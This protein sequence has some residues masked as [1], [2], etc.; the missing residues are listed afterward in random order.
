MQP[1]GTQLKDHFQSELDALSQDAAVFAASYPGVADALRL[2][3]SGSSD[4]HVQMLL[5]TF[6]FLT[7]RVR[8][9]MQVAKAHIPNA[10]LQHL[11]PQLA[12][13]LP[14]MMVAQLE[15]K[16]DVPPQAVLA[17]GRQ[18]IGLA[19]DEHGQRHP[20]RLRTA[21]AVPLLP[22]QVAEVALLGPEDFDASEHDEAV[23]ALLRLRIRRLGVTPTAELKLSGLR[24]YI[25]TAH[26]HAHYL[27][28]QLCLSFHGVQ[29]RADDEQ[30]LITQ[31][32]CQPHW[33]GFAE[34]EAALPARANSH[35]GHRLI[36]EYFSFPEKFMFFE[37]GPLDFSAI[38]GDFELHIQLNAPIDGQRQLAN[39]VL[40][41]N[42][43]PLVNLFAQR[44]DP[45]PLSHRHY[46]YRLRADLQNHARCEI[47]SLEE[48]VAI[49]ADGSLR[50]LR[51]YFEMRNLLDERSHEY[52]YTL[53]HERSQLGD[54]A[55]TEVYVS[56]LDTTQNLVLPAAEVIAG[57]ALCTNRRLP[58]QLRPGQALQLDGP[59]P[60]AG[61][62]LVSKP[63]PHT[64]PAL[65]GER[66]W[67]MVSQLSLNHLSMVDGPA[68]TATLKQ[69]LLAYIGP[70]GVRGVR[71]VDGLQG[72]SCR[73]IVRH[74]LSQGLRSF[75]HGLHIVLTFNRAPFEQASALLFATVL[76]HFLA[77][78]A[79]I[80]TVVE[81]A[82]ESTN[83][84][85]SLKQ[86][87]PLAGA[88]IVL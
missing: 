9:E 74:H 49:Q 32:Q 72:V 39:G 55:G 68:A 28:E 24:F 66:P 87:P 23:K 7:G 6:A 2:S 45:T 76:R 31:P 88:Q 17:R 5:Q 21:F 38:E 36:Q 67:T 26:K 61:I 25:D 50:E 77:L 57:R 84:K 47:H 15:V 46:E 13:P 60:I 70:A 73:H 82:Y 83:R 51:P 16:P 58:E 69:A 65:S 54:V 4:P 10:L 64:T 1:F 44:I 52:L 11:Q 30:P 62:E 79:S 40:K 22:L 37:L 59:G 42:C 43:V 34:D 86:W 71:Q 20:C 35:P 41:L 85:G 53:R 48:L 18:I 78:F 56:F 19:S 14:S 81:V 8:H 27:Y 63:T 12:A 80:N 29:L 33:L 3:R 75:V